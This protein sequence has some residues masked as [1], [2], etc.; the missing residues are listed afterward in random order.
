MDRDHGVAFTLDVNDPED[1][2][3]EVEFPLSDSDDSK[4][5]Y[6]ML[7]EQCVCAQRKQRDKKIRK[8][9]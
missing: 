9:N 5:R 4:R 7:T 8:T 3:F 6:E 1:V 2:V